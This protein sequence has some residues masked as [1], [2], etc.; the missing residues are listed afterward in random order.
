MR[1]CRIAKIYIPA[2]AS[3][4][5]LQKQIRTRKFKK[6]FSQNLP[7]LMKNFKSQA[8]PSFC[9]ERGGERKRYNGRLGFTLVE[10]L[11]VVAI[12]AV[13]AGLLLAVI[14]RVRAGATNGKT[15]SNLRQ[16]HQGAVTWAADNN[17]NFPVIHDSTHPL[18]DIWVNAIATVLYPEVVSKAGT[19]NTYVWN[20]WPKGYEG[21]VFRSPNAERGTNGAPSFNRSIP[22]YGYNNKFTRSSGR[23]LMVRFSP[24]KTVMFADNDGKSHALVAVAYP[25]Y[26]ALNPRN[27]ASAPYAG[28]GQ[29]AVIY[30]DGHSEMLS[31]EQCRKLSTNSTDPFWG[32]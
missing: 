27:G 14:G 12:V 5:L 31:A 4:R 19:A 2:V 8:V 10:L 17:G 3:S 21:T 16:L 6:E 11:T 24:S 26:G 13:L 15:L 29:A 28:D 20:V 18:G 22:S 32:K 23:N 1:V 9:R 30:L 25:G 7:S